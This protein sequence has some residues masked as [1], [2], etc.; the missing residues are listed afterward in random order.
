MEIDI[1]AVNLFERFNYVAFQQDI[2]WESSVESTINTFF[3]KHDLEFDMAGTW[4]YTINWIEL[5]WM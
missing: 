2:F 3:A 4:N 1:F 5:N